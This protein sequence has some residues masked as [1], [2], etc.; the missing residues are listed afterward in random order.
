MKLLNE[1]LPAAPTVAS[2]EGGVD[3]I[4]RLAEEW[5]RLCDEGPGDEPFYR[6]EWNISRSTSSKS[7]AR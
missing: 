5:R 2:E 4:D 3:V 6:P 1:T 7:T